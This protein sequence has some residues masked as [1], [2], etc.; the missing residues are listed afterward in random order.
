MAEVPYVYSEQEGNLVLN[1][2]QLPKILE[3]FL[4]DI[5]KDVEGVG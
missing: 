3:E 4:L 2:I 1:M 5:K